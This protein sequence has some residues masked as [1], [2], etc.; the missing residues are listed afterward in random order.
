M[1]KVDL[2]RVPVGNNEPEPAEFPIPSLRKFLIPDQLVQV[3][4]FFSDD[5][6]DNSV[7]GLDCQI[8]EW[9]DK[10]KNIIA[11]VGPLASTPKG[12][13]ISVTYIESSG[14]YKND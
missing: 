9:V 8:N 10:T 12:Y 1:N 5:G 11:T 13:S 3:K 14:N 2:S 7:I 4:T 6:Y